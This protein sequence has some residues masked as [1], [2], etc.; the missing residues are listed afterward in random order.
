MSDY[1]K[2]KYEKL[3]RKL[4]FQ[5]PKCQALNQYRIIEFP[6]FCYSRFGEYTVQCLSCGHK[7][8]V[9]DGSTG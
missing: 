1:Y 5:C 6:N 9:E 3:Q 4:K 7:Y 2:D 8:G